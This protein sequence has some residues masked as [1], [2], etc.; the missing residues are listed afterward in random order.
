[1]E[2]DRRPLVVLVAIVI[3]VA[4]F[5]AGV[6]QL[7]STPRVHPDE[8]I[9]AGA[10]A[11][12]GEGEGLR[13]RGER[14]ELGPVYPAI[15]APILTVA[16]S[17]ETAYHFYKA[18]NALLFALAA[19]PIYLVARRLLRPWWSVGVSVFSI[20]I[21]SSMYVALVMTESASYLAYSLALWAI[22]LALER[23]SAARQVGV[24]A[25]IALA[26]ATRAQ[27]AVLFG[28]YVV[29]LP[30]VWALV[31]RRPRPRE[32]VVQL[33]PTL[34]ALALAIA[35]LVVRPLATGASP[36]DAV[37]AYEVLFRGYDPLDIV[38]WGAYH[39]AD[40][41]LYLAVV[42]VA[43]APIV[44]SRLWR[45]GRDGAREA[46]AFLAAFVT[47]NAG[48]LFVTAAFASTEFG[49]DRLHDRNV[50]YLAPLWLLVLG[51]WLADG[52]P[53]PRVA[54]AVG[55]ASALS[56]LV[57]LPF[58]YIAS[59]VGVDVVPSALWARLQELLEGE[60]VT[61][62]KLMVLVVLGLLVLVAALP[63]RF[64]W[65]LPAVLLATF[66]AT[67]ALAWERIADATENSV[68]EG[69]RERGWVDRLL[70]D[71]AR[72]TKMYLVTDECPASALTW[73]ALY[74]TEFFN[75]SLE[76]AAYIDDSI[77]DG[78]PIRRVDVEPDGTLGRESGGALEAEYVITQPGIELVGRK[79][80]T[81][82]AAN[83]VL[84]RTAGPV[85]VVGA[86]SNADLRTA[87]CA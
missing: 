22:V 13:L 53:R 6:A 23:P 67:G 14:Y 76:R 64:W 39:L 83:L 87:D 65:V 2:T 25:A 63:R 52:L 10:A 38:K 9:Y 57:V 71:G 33:W 31:P 61:A 5:Y 60:I 21:P 36:L 85:R 79:L 74:L 80:G 34:A 46:A 20:A 27:F 29:A 15:L 37:G 12:L 58:R 66:A 70:P 54:T 68:F 48:M 47:V 86:G 44:L 28:A 72:V 45:R 78:L 30:A 82:T 77:A 19:L 43:V 56:L 69:S 11:S 17:R 49:F 1:M 41:E 18:L 50:F 75:R 59:D 8:H 26:Y 35:V 32:L 4:L 81:G 51:V 16:G 62:R 73:H 84:W 24:L 42:P 55:I 3:G 7:V 40:L